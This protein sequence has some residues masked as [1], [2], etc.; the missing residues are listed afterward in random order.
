[1]I[2]IQYKSLCCFNALGDPH[3]SPPIAEQD[4]PARCI[5]CVIVIEATCITTQHD[6]QKVWVF[7]R[8]TLFL[9]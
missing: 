1:M 6:V 5:H 7:A 9:K 8:C 3:D 2:E 4:H